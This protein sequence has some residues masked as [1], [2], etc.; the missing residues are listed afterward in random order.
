MRIAAEIIRE[1]SAAAYGRRDS[2]WALASALNPPGILSTSKRPASVRRWIDD[3]SRL[4]DS[5]GSTPPPWPPT[6]AHDLIAM[7]Q[8]RLSVL[9]G[10]RVI[11]CRTEIRRFR[12]RLRTLAADEVHD[13]YNILVGLPGATPPLPFPTLPLADG[14]FPSDRLSRP[15]RRVESELSSSTTLGAGRRLELPVPR[16]RLRRQQR[17]RAHR[18][19]LVNGRSPASAIFAGP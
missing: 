12:H 11:I 2:Q 18:H 16:V 1:L 13:R 4:R 15:L 6:Y 7:L 8:A 3:A 19:A 9:P 5:G 17:S 14:F 10:L